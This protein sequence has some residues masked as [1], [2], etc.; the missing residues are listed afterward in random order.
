MSANKLTNP[1]LLIVSDLDGT[2]L[3]SKSEL[4]PKTEKVIKKLK[5]Q[6]HVFCIATGRPFRGSIDI[7]N[8]LELDTIMVNHN[9]SLISNPSNKNFKEI[10]LKFSSEIVKKILSNDE[11][12]KL[13][14]NV[15]I[16]GSENTWMLNTEIDE[17]VLEYSKKIL[18]LS[19][20]IVSKDLEDV[21]NLK[22]DVHSTLLY[23]KNKDD[24]DTIVY[25]IKTVASTLVV[26][27]WSI[28]NLGPIIEINSNFS[29]K[30]TALEYLSSYY[31]IPTDMILTFG[32]GDNDLKMLSSAKFGFAM[33]NAGKP[34]KLAARHMTKFTN[35]E[36]GVA[37]EI[38]YFLK[39]KNWFDY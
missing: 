31:G 11:I 12:T 24:F 9:G 4:S 23:L 28:P 3:N 1:K 21:K 29:D 32:D 19:D 16:E 15:L 8:K 34:A 14:K 2:L 6:G 37:W 38:E 5:E 30:A 27:E 13:I 35:D 7:Y 22:E 20:N 36:D 33:K 25:W 17:S 10:H 26:R 18:N 39:K